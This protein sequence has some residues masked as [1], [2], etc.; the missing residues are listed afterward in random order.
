MHDASGN[1]TR[2]GTI[3]GLNTVASSTMVVGK[4]AYIAAGPLYIYDVSTSTPNLLGSIAIATG[5]ATSAY[6]AGNM[7][8]SLPMVVEFSKFTTSLIL[9]HLSL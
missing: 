8:T 2:R 5:Q 3:S 4:N 9:R 7:L 1:P 6:I